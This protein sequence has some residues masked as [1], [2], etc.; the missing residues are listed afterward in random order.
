MAEHYTLKKMQTSK[1]ESEQVMRANF[2][3]GNLVPSVRRYLLVLTD[4]SPEWEIVNSN[5]QKLCQ[6][7]LDGWATAKSSSAEAVLPCK[8]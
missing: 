6:L 7:W 5:H 4:Q 8:I 2:F 1:P 3:N